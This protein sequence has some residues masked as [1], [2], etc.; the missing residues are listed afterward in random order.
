MTDLDSRQE[1]V[2]LIFIASHGFYGKDDK[3]T[4]FGQD[5]NDEQKNIFNATT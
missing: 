2:S 4:S 1:Q 3:E 5:D